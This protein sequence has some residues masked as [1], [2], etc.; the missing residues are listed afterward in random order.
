MGPVNDVTIFRPFLCASES[1]F[2]R[3]LADLGNMREPGLLVPQANGLLFH[4]GHITESF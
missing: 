3:N 4:H 1:A 2:V